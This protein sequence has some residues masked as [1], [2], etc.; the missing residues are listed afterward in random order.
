MKTPGPSGAALTSGMWGSE[1]TVLFENHSFTTEGCGQF[2]DLTEDVADL[3]ERSKVRDGMALVYVP[4][5]TCAVIINESEDG[6]IA[7]FQ[8]MLDTLVPSRNYY[9]RHDDMSIRTQNIDPSDAPNGHSHC[10]GALIGS[11]SQTVPI[12]DGRLMLGRW[13]RIFFLELDH[14]RDRKVFIQVMGA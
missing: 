10:R 13:Q 4:H 2:L 9:Y 5:T 3:V 14:S 8:Q 11:N 6:F 7:D 12:R 1:V